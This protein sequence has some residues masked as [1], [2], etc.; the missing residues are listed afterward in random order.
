[1]LANNK[2]PELRESALAMTKLSRHL[3]DLVSGL[4]QRLR[5]RVLDELGLVIGLQDLVW[6]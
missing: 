4:L 6:D 2:Y 5:P 1:M 3:M